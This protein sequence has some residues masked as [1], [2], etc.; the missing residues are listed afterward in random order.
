MTSAEN[1]YSRIF[2]YINGYAPYPYQQRV[3]EFLFAGRNVVLRAPTGAGKTLAVLV[4]FFCER[5]V[6]KPSRLI[7]ALPLRTLANGIYAEARRAA[8]T[9]GLPV[10]SA[11]DRGREIVSPFITIQ[12]GEQPDDPFFDRGGII[13]TTYDQV[14]SGLLCSPYSLS[15]RLHNINA[16]AIAGAI[17]VFDEF[18]L[19]PT[20]KAFLTAVAGLKLF[21]RVCQS[22]WMTAT[23]TAPLEN[24][25]RNTLNAVSIPADNPEL[26]AMLASLLSVRDVT[27]LLTSET[28]PINADAI[29]RHHTRRSIAIVNTVKR[30][31]DLYLDLRAKFSSDNKTKLILLH[32][33]FFKQ[34]RSRLEKELRNLF[35]RDARSPAILVATQV[36]EA[37]ID[38][39]CEQLHTELCP[40][41]SFAQRA[42]RCARYP[43]ETGTV[44]VY[45]LPNES[46]AWLPY[47]EPHL[48][49]PCM[50]TTWSILSSASG[51]HLEPKCIADWVEAVHGSDDVAAVKQDYR[52]RLREIICCIHQN[53]IQRESVGVAHLIRGNDTESVRLLVADAEHLPDSPAKLDTVSLSRWSLA[54]H[55]DSVAPIGWYWKPDAEP[56]WQPLLQ[57]ASLAQTYAVC[58]RPDLAG[59]HS[60]LGLRLGRPGSSSPHRVE[61][62]RPGYPPLKE[63][64]WVNHAKMVAAEAER[65]LHHEGPGGLFL[66]G[67]SDRYS[68]ADSELSLLA[69]TCGFLHDLGKL[70]TQWQQWAERYQGVKPPAPLAHTNFD[71][72]SRAD[73]AR[74]ALIDI[75]RPP[76]ATA[77]AY[78]AVAL[79]NGILG[80]LAEDLRPPLASA[81]LAAIIS[82]HGSFL[83]KDTKIDLGLFPLMSGWDTQVSQILNLTTDNKLFASLVN[84]ADRRGLLAGFLSRSCGLDKLETWW[85][86][87]SFLM[88]NLRLSDQRATSEWSCRE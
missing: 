16:A 74:Q 45:P 6:A 85:P 64:L 4:P 35:G 80:H 7:Y 73:R 22:V 28:V 62:P 25:L 42:G 76:H 52:H 14:L 41:N 77:S 26:D 11:I 58:L 55:V 43:G 81:C 69:R 8:E 87:V 71:Y 38:I 53:S 48:P 66:H 24:L 50:Q 34:D 54:S 29:M 61:A 15:E 31:Q 27:R 86:L 39:S 75:K 2:R 19:M 23:A 12:T 84:Y 18:H 56:P 40:M 51:W 83:P 88:R 60:D 46:S 49:D 82:H 13:V 72:D 59:Y 32:S 17:V 47:G 44:H 21:D 70:Q 33:R 36:V 79:L 67:C 68:L 30:A 20:S 5:W 65:R 9:L 57:A 3:A 63:E 37:G 1:G 78:Y 10:E